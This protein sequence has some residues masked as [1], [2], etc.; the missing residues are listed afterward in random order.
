[1]LDQMTGLRVNGWG[2]DAK[3]MADVLQRYLVGIHRD[4][5]LVTALVPMGKVRKDAFA[6]FFNNG[7][8][9]YHQTD[10]MQEQNDQNLIGARRNSDA[11]NALPPSKVG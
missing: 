9:T 10:E 4:E 7:W 11:A 8:D 5:V 1:M 3:D 6:G 2:V